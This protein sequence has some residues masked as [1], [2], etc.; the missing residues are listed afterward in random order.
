[1]FYHFKNIDL[2]FLFE[3]QEGISGFVSN[4][5]KNAKLINGYGSVYFYSSIGEPEFEIISDIDDEKQELEL[6]SMEAH[7]CGDNVWE[8]S[9]ATDITRKEA[10]PLKRNVVFRD[11]ETGEGLVPIGLRFSDVIPSFL[12][13][14]VIK[15][16][17]VAFAE[18]VELYK[19]E[20]AYF[21][22]C[23]RDENGN[24][25]EPGNGVIFPSGLV[26]NHTPSPDG[27]DDESDKSQ[28]DLYVIL[29][30]KIKSVTKGGMT[31]WWKIEG[32]EEQSFHTFY[33]VNVDTLYGELDLII[34]ANQLSEE[35]LELLEEGSVIYGAYTLSGDVVLDEFENGAVYNEECCLRLL[36]QGLV[37]GETDRCL[38][39][40]GKNCEF[41]FAAE[42][43][44]VGGDRNAFEEFK[45]YQKSKERFITALAS[46]SVVFDDGSVDYSSS[47]RCVA[48]SYGN[49]IAEH[50]LFIDTLD[51]GKI[52]KL[53]IVSALGFE[54][55]IDRPEFED[56][57]DLYGVEGFSDMN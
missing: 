31:N 54:V 45:K 18:T 55:K 27:D 47:K 34:G 12:P 42:K 52:S 6:A 23:D 29:R 38:S 26:H 11:A 21:D 15:M 57:D 35:Q 43:I 19:D 40:F 39:A 22:A 32:E 28:T 13:D 44:K 51:D 36:R 3:K 4:V 16:Q 8:M 30:S 25:V 9:V 53:K 7:V 56:D 10:H 37:K 50:L 48:I 20:Q 14:D 24:I 2:D 49:E 41:E 17:V 46:A 33:Y 5:L 1:M